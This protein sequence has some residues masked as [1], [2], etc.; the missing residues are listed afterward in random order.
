MNQVI[1]VRPEVVDDLTKGQFLPTILL[2]D[3]ARDAIVQGKLEVRRGQ[4]LVDGRTGNRGQYL[5]KKGKTIRVRSAKPG[6][7]FSEYQKPLA[8]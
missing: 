7:K 2:T 1:Y 5:G 6:L 4:W 8:A 3:A